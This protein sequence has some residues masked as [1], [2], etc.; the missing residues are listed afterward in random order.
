M[1]NL[2]TSIPSPVAEMELWST[3]RDILYFVGVNGTGK[4]TLANMVAN[5]CKAN[6]G[7]VILDAEHR[8]FDRRFMG[9]R[10]TVAHNEIVDSSLALIDEWKRSDANLVIVDR[11]YETYITE[12]GLPLEYVVEIEGA[13][14]SSGFNVHLQHLVI[15]KTVMS[16]DR[17]TKLAR[18][19]HT[20]AHRPAEWW[21]ESRGT[22]EERA[23]ADCR[24]QSLN[25]EFCSRF[26]LSTGFSVA[27]TC[28]SQMLWDT[29]V[30]QL[31]QSMS[32]TRR[33]DG[34]SDS[35]AVAVLDQMIAT[36]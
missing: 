12:C 33:W 24:Y 5:R 21:D 30:D 9:R 10:D 2:P 20:K 19:A 35:Q 32:F 8:A 1:E 36:P 11:W 27:T 3:A 26:A 4:T 22:L 34:F 16:D 6:G 31:V 29:H 17:E 28:T 7:S 18:L 23:E 15:G 25:R 13:L 14:K